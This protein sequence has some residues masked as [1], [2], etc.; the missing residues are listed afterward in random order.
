MGLGAGAG[1]LVGSMISNGDVAKSALLGG[2]IGIPVG[3][4]AGV[5]YRSHM[6]KK[7]LEENEKIIKANYKYITA[8]AVEIE[9]LREK[10]TED[11]FRIVPDKNLRADIY[12]G[13]TIGAYNR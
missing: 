11:S 2:A 1:A 13:P 7:A 10:L 3:V 9:R 6:E 4:L 12:T 5:A 8:R